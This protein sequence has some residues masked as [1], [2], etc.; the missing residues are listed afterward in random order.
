MIIISILCSVRLSFVTKEDMFGNTV[1]RIFDNP[2]CR[3][4]R[5]FTMWVAGNR[6]P[7]GQLITS[8]GSSASRRCG[9]RVR[10]DLSSRARYPRDPV[11]RTMSPQVA[12]NIEY[13]Y[14]RTQPLSRS[15]RHFDLAER[16]QRAA[17]LWKALRARYVI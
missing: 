15:P 2:R 5:D 7:G 13:S 3:M 10:Y 14:V 1:F 17:A 12:G 4:R 16:I 9:Q 6:Q 8:S 11:S